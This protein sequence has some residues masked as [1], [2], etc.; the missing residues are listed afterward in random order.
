MIKSENLTFE[1]KITTEKDG[2]SIDE[3]IKALDSVNIDIKDGDFVAILGHNGSGKSTFAKHINALLLPSDGTMYVNGYNTKD[4]EKLWDIRQSAGMVFQNPDNQMVATIVEEDVAFGPENLGVP[5]EEIRKRVDES[6]K[7]VGMYE[8]KD[9]SP[10]RLSGGQKQRI[11]IAGVLAM[12][13]K[14]IILD[15][16]TAMLDPMGRKEVINTV[17]KLNKKFNMTV[18]LITHY[19]NEAVLAD[20]VFV[21]DSGKLVMQG[22]PREIF[23]NPDK[24]FS[25]GLDVPQVTELSHMLIKK[26]VNIRDD[27]LTVSEMV[28]EIIKKA[29]KKTVFYHTENAKKEN[30][31]E[32]VL[33]LRNVSHVYNEGTVFKK[34]ALNNINLEIKKGEFLGLIGHT[35]SGK[36]TLIQHLN[37]LLKPTSGEILL[38]GKDDYK[39]VNK[40]KSI[41]QKIGLVFQYPEH[42]LFEMTVYKDIAFAPTNLGLSEEEIKERVDT[43]AKTAGLS[44]EIYEKSPFDL[45]G[46]QKRRVAIAGI[47]AMKPDV[48][49]LDEPT[50]GLDPKG[51]DEIL[52]AV[53]KMHDEFGMTVILVSHSM[54]DISK[55][56]DRIIVMYGGEI[57]KS[58]TPS[59]IFEDANSLR[60]IGLDVPQITLLFKEL[61]EKGFNLPDNIFTV[62]KAFE[63]IYQLFEQVEK[64]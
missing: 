23:K 54:E 36:S 58:G 20:K 1:Y 31:K 12:L 4:L 5:S 17:I 32:T 63:I 21:M 30:N 57:Y 55:I 52:S 64:Q 14:C 25:Y 16:P 6:L 24:L 22:T 60:K 47:L 28:D 42:Q 27:I 59:E 53:K 15:E 43:A 2:K 3:T 10:A 46:G 33:S 18:I 39:D 13:P 26:G 11:A 29:S 41:R 9:A 40:L 62:D 49:V 51:R 19:M 56:A 50:A 35:G 38:Y 37:A 44:E 7:S 45:S 8:F 34:T 48:L 61:N